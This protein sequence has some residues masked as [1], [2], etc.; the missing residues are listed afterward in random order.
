MKRN[1]FIILVKVWC[2]KIVLIFL[3]TKIFRPRREILLTFTTDKIHG[4]NVRLGAAH[5]APT[6]SLRRMCNPAFISTV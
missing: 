4:R 6:L 5:Q 3:D 2:I 1:Y